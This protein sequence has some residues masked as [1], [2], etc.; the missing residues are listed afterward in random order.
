VLLRS[1]M[2]L[3]FFLR[4][5]VQHIL[6][7]NRGGQTSGLPTLGRAVIR[8]AHHHNG[9]DTVVHAVVADAAEPALAGP[10]RGAEALAPHDDGAEREALDLEAEALLHVVVPDDVDLVGDAGVLERAGEVVG[11]GGRE[12]VVVVLHPARGGGGLA[13]A[14]A[15]L[16]GGGARVG[17]GDVD[18]A[19][20]GAVEH[21]G[22]AH[23][24]QD[25]GVPGA[26]VVGDGPAHGV[27]GLVGEVDG[28]GDAAVGGSQG[29]GGGGGG[30][31]DARGLGL[32]RGRRRGP[33]GRRLHRRRRHRQRQVDGGGRRRGLHRGIF[34]GDRSWSLLSGVEVLWT[35]E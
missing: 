3:A 34:C 19:P 26:E 28:D 10:P 13:V 14:V 15:V 12:G 16:G 17:E 31:E 21:G 2:V 18:G 5:G 1:V 25:D 24:E 7:T 23:V 9:A 11:L 20:V 33:R 8:E 32:Q 22:G 6:S 29:R 4:H 27:G 30:E 35:G